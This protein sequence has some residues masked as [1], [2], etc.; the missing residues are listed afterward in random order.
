ML[1]IDTSASMKYPRRSVSD[2]SQSSATYAKSVGVHG[3]VVMKIPLLAVGADF[4][5]A[6]A[7]ICADRWLEALS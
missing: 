4:E 6:R 7:M 1:F 2:G 3:L 5:Y